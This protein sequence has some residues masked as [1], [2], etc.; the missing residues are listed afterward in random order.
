MDAPG[1]FEG[2]LNVSGGVATNC[3]GNAYLAVGVGYARGEVCQTGGA[4]GN[5]SRTHQ[6]IVGAFGGTGVWRMSGGMS[7]SAGDVYVGGIQT[8]QMAHAPCN[9]H[10]VA[11]VDAQSATGVV[12][13]AGGT[14]KAAG[15]LYAGQDGVA[16]LAVG[17]S[18]RIEAA[19]AVLKSAALSFAFGADGVGALSVPG[20]IALGEGVSLTVDVSA[21]SGVRR[22]FRLI[23]CPSISGTFSSIDV[24]GGGRVVQSSDGYWM[25]LN[26]GTLI[27]F[28]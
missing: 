22:H 13:V 27:L 8:N 17:P 1:F 5:G 21:Y 10:T 20:S 6:T 19:N 4:I 28:R 24:L 12:E 11:R 14:F 18:G 23:E 15:T 7:T 3:P 16:R 26:K 2:H 9:L 25:D